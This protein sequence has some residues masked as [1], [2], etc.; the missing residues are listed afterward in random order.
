MSAGT[1]F[2]P[3][4]EKICHSRDWLQW[5]GFFV[6][7]SYND[8]AQPEYAAIRHSAALIDVSPLYKYWVTGPDAVAMTNRIVTQDTSKMDVGQV[9]YTP[10]CDPDGTVRQEGTIFRHTETSFQICAAEPALGWLELNSRG[11][12][13]SITDRSD[14]TAALSLQGPNSRDIL[15]MVS[16]VPIDDMKFFRFAHGQIGSVPVT[17]SRTGYT[18]DLGYE[19]WIPA[20]H[21]V[22]VWDILIGRGAAY[23]ITPCGLT[24]MD[25][26]RVE[27]GFILINV[28]YVSSEV[29]R[30]PSH[31]MSAYELNLGWAVKLNKEGH[32]VG[33]K[34]LE[35]EKLTGPKRSVVGIEIGWKPLED[36]YGKANLMPD[37]PPTPCREPVPVYDRNGT[38]IGRVTTRVWSGLL[39]KYI[40]LATVDAAFAAPGTEVFMEVT[41]DFQ[42]K[43]VPARVAKTPFYRPARMRA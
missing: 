31:R 12:D 28:D 2:H 6:A 9:L 26:S 19:I 42:R 29:A 7:N 17:I 39:K 32:F 25:T 14:A 18:G 15:Q 16:S 27:A 40:G 1:A 36:I 8:F 22:T 3:R 21:A 35:R 20:E 13:V 33:R 38:N 43:K 5:S 4:T 23:H 34:A 11:F 24:A 10:W 37:L 30:L 41:I